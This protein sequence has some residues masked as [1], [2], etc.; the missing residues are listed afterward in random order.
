MSQNNLLK[1]LK[2]R[3]KHQTKQQNTKTK[4]QISLNQKDLEWSNLTFIISNIMGK[5]CTW[6][7]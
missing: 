7:G 4:H 3:T 6:H 2:L 1:L 5:V